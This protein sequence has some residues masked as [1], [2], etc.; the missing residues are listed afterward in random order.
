MIVKLL[1]L[2]D[3]TAAAAVVFAQLGFAHP[4]ILYFFAVYLG[5][6]GVIFIKSVSSIL[7]ILSALYIVFMIFGLKS[8]FAYLIAIYL[9][10]KALFSFA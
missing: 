2:L 1:G 5:F 8:F 3:L 10:Q 4:S 9:F 7:D 6:K